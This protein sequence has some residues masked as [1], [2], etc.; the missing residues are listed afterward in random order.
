MQLP[1]INAKEFLPKRLG[2]SEFGG[3]G[4]ANAMRVEQSK[5]IC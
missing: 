2:A 1:R 3:K 4:L 5:K